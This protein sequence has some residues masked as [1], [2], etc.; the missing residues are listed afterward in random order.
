VAI[1]L[2]AMEIGGV[3]IP[4]EVATMPGRGTLTITGQAGEVMQESA[5]AA[6]S[7]GTGA[8]FLLCG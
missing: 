7:E 5:R 3:M 6:L 4:A 8:M 2:G 1:G